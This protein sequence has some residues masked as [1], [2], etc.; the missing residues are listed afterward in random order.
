MDITFTFK[1]PENIAERL[2]RLAEKLERPKSYIIRKALERFLEE[3]IEEEEDYRIA[4]QR[5]AA[6]RP[7]KRIPWE[8]VKRKHGLAD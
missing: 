3:E 5:L 4:M 1:A 8:E 6:D 2:N 7:D